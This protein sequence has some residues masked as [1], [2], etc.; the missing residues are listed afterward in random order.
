[1]Q[2]YSI[3]KP[4]NLVFIFRINLYSPVNY[5]DFFD[6]KF[7]SFYQLKSFG[8]CEYENKIKID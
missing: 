4:M 1:M 5:P 7:I 2:E 6:W 8:G 3:G